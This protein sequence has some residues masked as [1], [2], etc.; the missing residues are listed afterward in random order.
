[1][2]A[3][4]TIEAGDLKALRERTQGVARVG[5]GF[6]GIVEVLSG[7]NGRLCIKRRYGIG[8][9]KE[10]LPNLRKHYSFRAEFQAH[11]KAWDLGLR[12]PR[13]VAYTEI[14]VRNAVGKKVSDFSTEFILMEALPGKT[15]LDFEPDEAKDK[16]ALAKAFDRLRHDLDV[17]HESNLY[18]GDL[19]LKNL[20]VVERNGEAGDI[21]YDIYIIDFGRA[22]E[23]TKDMYADGHAPFAQTDDALYKYARDRFV[24]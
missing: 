19:S 11:V 21:E 9:R 13:L 3:S 17:M 18:H 20:M 16:E 1:M 7:T 24:P 15:L 5:Q 14:I 10:R 23:G 12:V 22:Y 6:E 8:D 2:Y 4:R